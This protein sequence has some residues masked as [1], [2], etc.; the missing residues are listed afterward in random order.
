MLTIDKVK[1]RNFMSYGGAWSEVNFAKDQLTVVASKNGAG[2]CLKADSVLN[3]RFN[4]NEAFEEFNR[5]RPVNYEDTITIKELYD[6]YH[7]FPCY[8]GLIDVKGRFGYHKA[9]YCDITAY[10]SEIIR[11]TVADGSFIETSPDHL[12]FKD[13]EWTKVKTL[14]VGDELLTVN[15]VQKITDISKLDELEDLFD[16]Q[17]S[18]VHELYANGFV[19]HNST[20]LNTITFGLFNRSLNG[21][22]KNKLVNSINGKQLEVHVYFT[23]DDIHYRVVRGIKPSIFQIYKNEKLINE[24]SN[25]RDYQ[26]VLESQIL[27]MSYKT[28]IQTITIGM[29]NFTP[30]MELSSN[31]RRVV[32]EDLLGVGILTTMN[33][34]LKDKIQTNNQAYYDTCNALQLI[35]TQCE[36]ELAIVEALKN[37]QKQNVKQLEKQRAQHITEI[38]KHSSKIDKLNKAIDKLQPVVD[39]YELFKNSLQTVISEQGKLKGLIVKIDQDQNFIENNDHCPL[40]H[41]T[42][43]DSY[44]STITATNQ[45][46]KDKLLTKL[47]S[48]QNKLNTLYEKQQKFID[49]LNKSN[50]LQSNIREHNGA[51][52]LLNNQVR[53]IDVKLN[54]QTDSEE[55]IAKENSIHEKA[56]KG[57]QLIEDKQVQLENKEIYDQCANLLKDSGIKAA[58]VNQY[59][60]I[61]NQMINKYLADMDFFLTFEIDNQFNETLKARGRDDMSYQNLSQGEKRRLDMAILFT[62]RYIA[63]LRNSCSCSN[64]FIDEVLDSSLD[65]AGIESIMKLFRSFTDSN[66]FVIS[67]R[68]G[69]QELDFDRIITIDKREQFSIINE[70]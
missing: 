27:K 47:D 11:V 65:A 49:V 26:N 10:H 16:V 29:S 53:D 61:I 19:S 35:K 33:T 48:I 34:V 55:I 9:Q 6:F 60:P 14:T 24:D 64:I 17:V 1:F 67:H 41:Q 21:A 13:N 59:L 18:E 2:K 68:E 52:T 56:L 39:K 28:F 12:L 45:T 23:V 50:E 36:S 51:I 25:S 20:I 58:V 5:Y 43:D 31:D 32:V 30:F 70:Q 4:D 15:G 7:D 62:W 8:I 57:K 42:I 3:I 40:C 22:P 63:Q 38:E 46:N 37:N 66:I 54:T 44:R 69:V